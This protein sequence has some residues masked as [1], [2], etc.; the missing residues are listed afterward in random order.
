MYN[1]LPSNSRILH[2]PENIGNNAKCL[3]DKEKQQGY[4]SFSISLRNDA[5]GFKADQTLVPSGSFILGELA[6]WRLLFIAL[7]HFDVIHFNN[8]KTIMPHRVPF[9]SIRARTNIC[10]AMLYQPYSLLLEGRDLALLKLFKKRLYFTFQGSD[11]RLSTHY[12]NQ[13]SASDLADLNPDYLSLKADDLKR[14]RIRRAEKYSEKIFCLNPDLLA[15]FSKKA[16]FVPYLN[17]DIDAIKTHS[18]F[19]NDTIHIVHAPSKRDIK[20][21]RHIIRAV[22]NLQQNNPKI[23]FTLVENLTNAEAQKIYDTAD[24]FIDQL[25]VGWY[26]GVSVELMARGVPTICYLDDYSLSRLPNNLREQLPIIN[27]NISNVSNVLT[28]VIGQPRKKLIELGIESRE[29]CERFHKA[30]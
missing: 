9:N 21:S 10:I 24:L 15:N 30:V 28:S 2:C 23:I 16:T 8:G 20:G 19:N 12:T 29:Y 22:E 7:F 25:I 4:R 18:V 17:V 11:A 3:S 14:N 26:G 5:F 6:R 1:K 27:V 13:H